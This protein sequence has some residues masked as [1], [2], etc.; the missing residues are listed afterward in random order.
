MTSELV[1]IL[2]TQV[3]RLLQVDRLQSQFEV[4]SIKLLAEEE[5]FNI[6][7]PTIAVKDAFRRRFSADAGTFDSDRFLTATLERRID[8]LGRVL[9]SAIDAINAYRAHSK[10]AAVNSQYIGIFSNIEPFFHPSLTNIPIKFRAL[11]GDS[12]NG[13]FRPL[14]FSDESGALVLKF[15]DPRPYQVMADI[16]LALGRHLG[17]DLTPPAIFADP[18]NKWY[19]IEYFDEER[20]NR[21]CADI[22]AFVFSLGALTSA[23]Y[24]LR[25]V[26]LHLENMI[27]V[28]EKPVIIDPECIFYSFDND[29]EAER[30]LN[31]GLLSHNVHLSALRGGSATGEPLFS[32]DLHLADNG[33]LKYRKPIRPMRNRARC[34][35]GSTVDPANHKESLIEGYK[36]AYD[37]FLHNTNGVCELIGNNVSEDFRV[38]YLARKTRH[39]ASIIHM[40]N[41]P[42]VENYPRWRDEIIDRF[43]QSGHFPGDISETLLNAEIHDLENRDIPYFWVN[44]GENC[45]HHRTGSVQSY[46]M[47]AL[48]KEQAVININRLNSEN[49]ALQL[50]TLEEFLS[51]DLVPTRNNDSTQQKSIF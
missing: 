37:W 26:D 24:C 6:L 7:E 34:S 27:I 35:D 45:I 44:A 11:A 16:L 15:A 47:P 12:H 14:A 10:A 50:A 19:F 21:V 32:F 43:R 46:D 13:G 30:L 8:M 39:Y 20:S 48:I 33:L 41:L 5:V 29:N 28:D 31:T 49:L 25:M 22:E 51:L 40:L 9:S 2:H 36:A 3:E 1:E 42:N 4:S 38:R 17:V 18:D 23:A